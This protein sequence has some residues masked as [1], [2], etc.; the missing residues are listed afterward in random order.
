MLKKSF[1]ITILRILIIGL[2]LRKM[3]NKDKASYVSSLPWKKAYRSRNFQ[4]R[5]ILKKCVR[6]VYK[7]AD[8]H[9]LSLSHTHTH[10][11]LLIVKKSLHDVHKVSNSLSLSLSHIH[12]HTHTHAH[13][14]THIHTHTHTHTHT[15]GDLCRHSHTIMIAKKSLN[16]C[17]KSRTHFLSFSL[18]SIYLSLSLSRTHTQGTLFRRFHALLIVRKHLNRRLTVT[19]MQT[20]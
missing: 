20:H 3:T 19:N 1:M 14:H 2:F 15:W 16:V 5:L 11:D 17:V 6:D 8:T 9:T 4:A 13:T 10:T 12:T 18:L 7:V